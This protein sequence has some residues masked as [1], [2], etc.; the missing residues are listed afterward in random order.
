MQWVRLETLA[1][2]GWPGPVVTVGNFDGVHRGH[3]VLVG[4]T[5]EAARRAGGTSVVLT[6]DP[7]PTRVLSPDRAPATL[8]TLAQ[9]GE[10]L[11]SLG[12]ERLAVLPFTREVASHSPEEFARDV[13]AG[14]LG[15][16]AVVVGESFRFGRGRRGDAA[17]LEALGAG[18]GFSVEAVPPIVL[19]GAPVSSTR[20][21][22]ALQDGDV[23]V[24][25]RLLGRPAF[26]DALVVQGDGR[27]RMIG[28]PTAN[29]EPDNELLPAPGV[30]AG[31]CRLPEGGTHSA[32]VNLGR[33]PT[34]GGGRLTLEAHVLDFEGDLYG[35]RL[36]LSFEARLRGEERFATVAALVVQIHRDVE[37]ARARLSEDGG[38]KV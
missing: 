20:V 16:R 4:R 15:A 28:V 35:K 3:Q 29:L 10:L 12:I 22:E 5:V 2:R 13:L 18:L 36:R 25:A 32:V 31:R 34:F 19:D 27:G 30:Y 33:R 26:V 14:A 17:R 21:R 6:F 7:H 1:P 23:E 24:A 8:T 38:Q 9:K 11:T 37:E